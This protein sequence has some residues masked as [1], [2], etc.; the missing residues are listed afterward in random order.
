MALILTQKDA[1]QYINVDQDAATACDGCGEEVQDLTMSQ[2]AL[3]TG[4]TPPRLYIVKIGH[5]SEVSA[6]VQ[7]L[8][9]PWIP[10]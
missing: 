1:I 9:L 6:P 3:D 2:Y 8:L 10:A 7:A 4:E 5:E